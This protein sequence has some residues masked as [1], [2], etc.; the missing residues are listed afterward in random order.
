[1]VVM[2]LLLLLVLLPGCCCLLL[3]LFFACY[4]VSLYTRRGNQ[5]MYLLVFQ[6]QKQPLRKGGQSLVTRSSRH[7]PEAR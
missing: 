3:M 2:L 7:I 6:H 1:V 5:Q 4:L